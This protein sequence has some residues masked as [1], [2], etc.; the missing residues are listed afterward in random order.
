M[1]NQ[2]CVRDILLFI[3]ENQENDSLGRPKVFK[4]KTFCASSLVTEHGYNLSDIW[5]ATAYLCEKGCLESAD[6]RSKLSHVHI[7][8]ITSKG[9]D[10][11]QVI[12]NPKVWEALRKRFGKV[13]DISF[14]V[15]VEAFINGIFKA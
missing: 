13:F 1:L 10:Y 5:T 9:Y 2:E 6:W 15:I 3:D 12:K 11:I 8:R 4:M 7:S 14:S